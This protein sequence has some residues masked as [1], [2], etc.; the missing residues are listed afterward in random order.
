M[1]LA[2]FEWVNYTVPFHL[3]GKG[4]GIVPLPLWE[5]VRGRGIKDEGY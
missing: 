3:V 1:A 2:H 5:G 4:W